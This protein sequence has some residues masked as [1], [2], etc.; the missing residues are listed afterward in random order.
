MLHFDRSGSA[1]GT[2]CIRQQLCLNAAVHGAKEECGGV[3]SLANGEMAMILENHPL[4][5]A[6]GGSDLFAL[7]GFERNAAE[8]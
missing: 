6:Q 3:D 1:A 7:F 2:R 8:A 5:I 4:R